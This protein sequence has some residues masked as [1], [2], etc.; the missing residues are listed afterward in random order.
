[1]QRTSVSQTIDQVEKNVTLY[2]WVNSYRD[3]GK[4]V[5]FDLRDYTGLLQIVVN[6]QVSQKAAAKTAPGISLR[7]IPCAARGRG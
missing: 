3:H 6:P 1:M 7:P 2:G 4:L 5:F